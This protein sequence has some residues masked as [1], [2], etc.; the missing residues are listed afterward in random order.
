MVPYRVATATLSGAAVPFDVVIWP[1][2][3][4]APDR[5]DAATLARYSTVVLPDVF[6]LTDAQAAAIDGYLAEGGPWSSPPTGWPRTSR[7]TSA[8]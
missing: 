7:A 6:S 2:G 8:W 3:V 4:T 1:D 5:A